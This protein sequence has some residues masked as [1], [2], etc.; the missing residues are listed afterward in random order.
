[1]SDTD[2]ERLRVFCDVCVP[3]YKASTM[4]QAEITYRWPAGDQNVVRG[5]V[6]ELG[7]DSGNARPFGQS[8]R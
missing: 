7:G 4:E 2:L 1:M 8:W 5:Y 6:S 3:T